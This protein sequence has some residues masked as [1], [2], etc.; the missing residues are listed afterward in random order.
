MEIIDYESRYLDDFRR[1]NL[2]WLEKYH[3]TESHDLDILNDPEGKILAGG[4]CL[5]L[6]QE[7]G[8]IIGTAGL[9][10]AG[11]DIYELVK[12]AVH[13]TQRGKGIGKCLLETC[14]AE[15][16]KRQARKI[17]LFSNSQLTTAIQMYEKYGF[18][19]MAPEDSPLQTADVKMELTL[20]G[21]SLS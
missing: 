8:T 13:P 12:M 15:A 21:E 19:H 9:V 18:R 7:G 14:I 4:G 11:N 1:L 20:N 6:A 5:F 16:R 17:F 3:L 2:E 10:Y